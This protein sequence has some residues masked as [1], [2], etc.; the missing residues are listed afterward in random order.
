VYVAGVVTLTTL[1]GYSL[2]AGVRNLQPLGQVLFLPVAVLPVLKQVCATAF[3]LQTSQQDL[4]QFA[5]I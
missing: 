4:L 2:A 3:V 1:W 5:I